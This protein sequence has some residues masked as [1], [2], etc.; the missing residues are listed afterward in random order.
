MFSFFIVSLNFVT[1]IYDSEKILKIYRSQHI[2]HVYLSQDVR[3]LD[4]L[5][6]SMMWPSQNLLLY[7]WTVIK[8][9]VNE[10]Q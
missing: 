1:E 7:N 10:I 8:I 6:T 5:K 2:M 4:Q 3:I 9:Q